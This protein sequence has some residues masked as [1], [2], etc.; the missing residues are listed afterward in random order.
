MQWID[1]LPVV[2]AMENDSETL[3]M[4][5]GTVTE[6]PQMHEN[7]ACTSITIIMH[8]DNA[9]LKSETTNYIILQ[10]IPQEIH[11]TESKSETEFNGNPPEIIVSA[12][13][14]I[15]SGEENVFETEDLYTKA[16]NLRKR[17]KYNVNLNTRKRIRLNKLKE[18]HK[19]LP[20]C[21]SDKCKKKC[22]FKI[23]Q[24]QRCDINKKFWDLSWLERRTYI[25]NTCKR[26]AVKR[27][28]NSAESEKNTI[29][30]SIFFLTKV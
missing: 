22:N 30:L 15:Q 10:N 16:G 5:A 29:R 6:V 12:N 3:Q 21:D 1:S 23:S 24:F 27:R 7:I 8:E 20:S 26:F 18:D 17:R 2:F 4:D 9:L 11:H 19:P 28:P 13:P 14:L 25:F